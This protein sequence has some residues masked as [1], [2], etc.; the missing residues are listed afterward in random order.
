[1]DEFSQLEVYIYEE[2]KANLYVHHD[3]MLSSFPIC[4]EWLPV[5]PSSFSNAE[6]DRA[7]LAIVG[8]FLPDI[9]IWN[10]DILDAVEPTLILQ[11]TGP[12]SMVV[13]S[14]KKNKKK[15]ALGHSDAITSLHLNPFQKHILCSGSA[16][17]TIKLWD[18]GTSTPVM[19]H[20][21]HGHKPEVVLWHH[22]EQGILLAAT[23]DNML[24]VADVR[25]PKEVGTYQFESNLEGVT[26]DVANPSEI[27]I[28]FGNG[29]IGGLDMRAGMK[30]SY[31]KQLSAKGI[32]SMDCHKRFKG[33]MVGTSLDGFMVALNTCDRDAE[34]APKVVQR[35]MT[36]GVNNIY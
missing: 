18:I 12:D 33:L 31:S 21:C 10:L 2:N 32:S 5:E 16:D 28:S 13:H 1:M 27:H 4:L 15:T 8:T 34:N 19:T 9:E 24:R 17:S 22:S 23:D 29:M 30:P 25:T 36:Q 35:M 26:F 11:G 14:K 20:D 7:N 3:I 6:C